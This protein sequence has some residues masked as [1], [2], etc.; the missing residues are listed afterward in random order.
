MPKPRRARKTSAGQATSRQ[1]DLGRRLADPDRGVRAIRRIVHEVAEYAVG[2]RRVQQREDLG[3]GDELKFSTE[4][5]AGVALADAVDDGLLHS[6]L[7]LGDG[8]PCLWRLVQL[9]VRAHRLIGAGIGESGTASKR[10]DARSGVKIIN[11]KSCMSMGIRKSIARYRMMSGARIILGGKA[12]FMRLNVGIRESGAACTRAGVRS[13][14]KLI[15]PK[16]CVNMGIRTSSTR[17]RVM[18]G[19]R[20][21]HGGKVGTTRLIA[22]IRAGIRESRA[23]EMRPSVRSSVMRS[24]ATISK[25]PGTRASS[26]KIFMSAWKRRLG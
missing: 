5:A 14:A 23:T 13:S 11:R 4:Q 22:M 10:T 6:G 17:Y 24:G 12:C 7:L 18:S 1:E 19:A 8:R 3:A 21:V 2:A 15:N 9:G 16:P 25:G 20:K 26:G